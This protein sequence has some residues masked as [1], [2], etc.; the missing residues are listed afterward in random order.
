[1][2]QGKTTLRKADRCLE[3]CENK[4]HSQ[5]NTTEE[6]VLGQSQLKRNPKTRGKMGCMAGGQQKQPT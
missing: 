5:E 6:T 2:S 1:M 3:L 4:H